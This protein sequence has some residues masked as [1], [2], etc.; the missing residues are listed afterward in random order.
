M[1]VMT[2]GTETYRA[3]SSDTDLFDGDGNVWLAGWRPS[4]CLTSPGGKSSQA[5]FGQSAKSEEK[6]SVAL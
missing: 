5:G 4:F 3:V 2:V 1:L 6:M